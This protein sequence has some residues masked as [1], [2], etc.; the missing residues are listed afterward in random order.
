MRMIVPWIPL[1]LIP[2]STGGPVGADGPPQPI[3]TALTSR[4]ADSAEAGSVADEA[5]SI[6]EP[7]PPNQFVNPIG[8][9]ADPW[10]VRDPNHDRYLWCLS[11]GNRG[12]SIHTSKR[13]TSLGQKHVVWRAPDTGRWSREIWA[14]ELHLLD[15]KWHIYFAASD[16]NNANH[17]AYVLVSADDDP[18]GE[19]TL[20]GPLETGDVAGEPI[21]AIDMTV[22]EHAGRRYAIWSGWDEPGSDRQ[23]LYAAAMKSPTELSHSRV[24]ICRNDDFPWEFTEDD[25]RGRGLHEG[26]QVFTTDDRTLVIFSCAA[27]WLP[28]YKLGCLELT[29]PDPLDPDSWTKQERPVFS[30]TDR[31]Y[32]VGHSCFV[33]SPDGTE[34]WHVYHAKRD[35]TPGWRRS[36]F[37]Q[38]LEIGPRGFPRFSR[39]VAPGQPLQRPSGEPPLPPADLPLSASLAADCPLVADLTPYGHHQFIEFKTDGLHLGRVPD[40][41]VNDYRCG[42]KVMLDRLVPNDVS[43]EVTIRFPA[44]GSARDAG[45]LFHTT[46]SGVGYDAQRG[47][48][49]GLIPRNKLMV[50]GRTDGTQ[51]RE[52]SRSAI[53]IDPRMPQRLRLEIRGENLAGYLNGQRTLTARAPGLHAGQLGFRVVDTHAVF[54][55]L[56]VR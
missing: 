4:P 27:S 29:G 48:F 52:V 17:L 32:G 26:P 51:W 12:I 13:L 54:S 53:D 7:L 31:T 56:D 39:P 19:Y 46:G 10:V 47:F 28:T 35:P 6:V 24:R 34:L 21:W 50:F 22:L 40:Q 30:G 11:D 16:G 8:E 41:P 55:D 33:A 42:E 1:L 18:L 2:L 5:N 20:H 15:G 49:L 3:V 25:G 45:M 38:P 14:P 23:F 44:G 43:V 37:L 36:V 9:A